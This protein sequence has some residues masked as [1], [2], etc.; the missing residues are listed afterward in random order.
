MCR[1]T[2]AILHKY[3]FVLAYWWKS[4]YDLLRYARV[5]R[6]SFSLMCIVRRR[7]PVS[8][9]HRDGQQLTAVDGSGRASYL[10]THFDHMHREALQDP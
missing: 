3:V 2:V 1:V 8:V 7:C 5:R 10:T 4:V 9:D 6:S